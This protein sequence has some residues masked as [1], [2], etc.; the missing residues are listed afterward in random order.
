MTTQFLKN[1][2]RKPLL[3]AVAPSTSKSGTIVRSFSG[4]LKEADW[5]TEQIAPGWRQQI[6]VDKLGVEQ[7]SDLGHLAVFKNNTLGD[8]M[9][10]EGRIQLA[11]R[12][13]QA[14]HEMFAHVPIV[15]H[16]RV[17]NVLII[18]GGDGAT[19]REVLKHPSV[20][21]TLVDIDPSVVEFSK[22]YLPTLHQGSW[23][24]ERSTIVIDDGTKF[25]QSSKEKFD[26]IIIDSTDPVADGPSAVLYQEPFY[27]D[28]K[29]RLSEGGILVTQNGHPHFEEYPAVAL[30]TLA[31]IFKHTT[32]YQFCVP[33]YMGGLQAFG[34]ASDDG[35]LLDVPQEQLEQR[36]EQAGITNMEHYTPRYGKAS[37]ILP[38][39]MQRMVEKARAAA[40]R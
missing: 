31:K 17:K 27:R 23:D 40:G 34:W 38:Q 18:G 20:R 36:W 28:C 22:K 19:L 12:D 32:M 14:Y 3:Q 30:G 25:V 33:T 2:I 8:I 13:E 35:S 10:I 39:W 21:A 6:Q 1:V 15:G 4:I 7:K 29:A 24:H 5:V 11:S 9:V 26:V 16:G 37:F